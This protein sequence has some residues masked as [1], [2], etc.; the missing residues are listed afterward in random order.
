M[1]KHFAFF[2]VPVSD[3]AKAREFY[4]GKLGLTLTFNHQD[5]WVEYD[6]GESTIAI[7][8]M[9]EGLKPGSP[10]GTV[11]LEV[12][13][14]DSAVA[15]LKAQGVPIFKDIFESP[16]CRM[17]VVGD[18]DSNGIILHQCKEGHG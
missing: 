12:H 18:P 15:E 10:G 5:C 8:T 17:A 2:C 1:I 9:A 7:T 4:E 11:A 6:I 3:V 13:D 14:L 16:V